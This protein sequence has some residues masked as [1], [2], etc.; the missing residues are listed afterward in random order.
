MQNVVPAGAK[1]ILPGWMLKGGVDQVASATIPMTSSPRSASSGSSSSSGGTGDFSL[2]RLT[3][4]VSCLDSGHE[5]IACHDVEDRPIEAEY[6]AVTMDT[7]MNGL[8]ELDKAVQEN[9]HTF[10][11]HPIKLA[12]YREWNV[13]RKCPS[14]CSHDLLVRSGRQIG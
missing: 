2:P 1:A 5:K 8:R 9:A 14:I 3:L 10:I 7:M 11:G 4:V 12:A 13:L 6:R